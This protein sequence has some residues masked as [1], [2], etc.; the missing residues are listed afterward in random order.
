M[1]VG[2]DVEV[3]RA[4]LA[5]SLEAVGP[6]ASAGCGSWTAFDLAAHVVAAD[7]AAGTLAFCIRVLAARGLQFRPNPSIVAAAISRERRDG[8]PALITRLRRR[9]PRLLLVQAVAAA[10]LFEIWMHHDDLVTRNGLAH[11]TPTHLAQ[12]IPFLIRY[13]AKRLPSSGRLSVR[14]TDGHHWEFG[15]QCDIQYAEIAGTAANLIRWLAGR[16][17]ISA[18]TVQAEAGT[19]DQLQTFVGNI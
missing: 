14:T 13:H 18:L 9:P 19:V 4:A 6:E 2:E 8:Y 16:G 17:P 11:D 10:S 15:P 3:E 1:T 12:A 7:R 5:D